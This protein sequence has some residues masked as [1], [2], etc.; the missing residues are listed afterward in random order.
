M[1]TLTP[2]ATGAN[3]KDLSYSQRSYFHLINLILSG[4]LH[5][6][7]EVNRRQLAEELG[8]SLAPVNEAV[9]LLETEGFI[10]VTPRRQTRVKVIRREEV[11]GLLILREAIECQ[12][13][14]LYC[15]GPVARNREQL[16]ALAA[17][18]DGTL[19]GSM[20]NET[21]ECRLHF[22]LVDLVGCPLL[23]GEFGKVMRR[24]L[25]HKINLVMP[26][27]VRLPMGSHR[28]L[29]DRLEMPDPQEA[30]QAMRHHLE[31]GREGLLRPDSAS[32]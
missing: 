31:Q 22:A 23:S 12:A 29:L 21:A 4:T 11:R 26:S 2:D 19:A 6:G 20:G 25:F 30:E 27:H 13:A 16:S 15:G 24:R 18:V 7:D 28:A 5:P 8:I 32:A 3:A 14:R 17:A 9:A 10:E 1:T